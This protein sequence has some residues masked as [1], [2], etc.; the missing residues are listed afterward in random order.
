MCKEIFGILKL[1]NLRIQ[2]TGIFFN[3]KSGK[4]TANLVKNI[5]KIIFSGDFLSITGKNVNKQ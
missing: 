1:L 2:N 4:K 5:P 3:M